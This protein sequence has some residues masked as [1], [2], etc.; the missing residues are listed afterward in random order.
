[1]K[2]Q[3]RKG[4]TCGDTLTLEGTPIPGLIH[5]WKALW[6]CARV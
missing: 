4:M 2:K 6:E 1:M 5:P 3:N